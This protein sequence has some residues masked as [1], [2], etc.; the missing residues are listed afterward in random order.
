MSV[1]AGEFC[2][3][4]PRVDGLFLYEEYEVGFPSTPDVQLAPYIEEPGGHVYPY[5]P[6]EV[7]LQVIKKHGGIDTEAA[8]LKC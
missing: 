1:Q 8:E 6:V 4:T 7:V 3:C 2:Y 5:V